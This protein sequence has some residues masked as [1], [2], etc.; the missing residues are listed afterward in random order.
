MAETY[1]D[2]L[3]ISRTATA[4]EIKNAYREMVKNVHPDALPNASDFWRKKAEEEFKYVQEAYSVLSNP[5]K[6][7]LYDQQLSQAQPASAPQAQPSQAQATAAPPQV[8]PQPIPKNGQHLKTF[9]LT[10]IGVVWMWW[11]GALIAGFS[12]LGDQPSDDTQT[13]VFSIWILAIILTTSVALMRKSRRPN[14]WAGSIGMLLAL[15]TAVWVVAGKP[16]PK[17][18]NQASGPEQAAVAVSNASQGSDSNATQTSAFPCASDM[19]VSPIDH[20]P[21]PKTNAATVP[22]TLPKDFFQWSAKRQRL[23]QKCRSGLTASNGQDTCIEESLKRDTNVEHQSTPKAVPVGSFS[24][25]PMVGYGENKSFMG[26]NCSWNNVDPK[27]KKQALETGKMPNHEFLISPDGETCY[28]WTN[29]VVDFLM[30]GAAVGE[31]VLRNGRII[32]F[33]RPKLENKIPKQF[34]NAAVAN[35]YCGI[36]TRNYFKPEW[37]YGAQEIAHLNTGD[38]VKVIGAKPIEAQSGDWIY[39]VQSQFGYRGWIRQ[40]CVT[41]DQQ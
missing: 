38:R 7:R 28:I 12:L 33:K 35:R 5:P 15:V 41:F 26:T 31:P 34:G 24:A 2:I 1:Y 19:V 21:C 39:P 14:Q 37:E 22:E 36:Y 16:H 30:R 4:Q 20:K 18:S 32:A 23:Y 8:Q 13:A 11:F 10:Y 29:Q 27:S 25:D 9:W 17:A 6:R 3:G 40:D